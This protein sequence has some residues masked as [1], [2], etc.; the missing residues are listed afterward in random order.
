MRR[1]QLSLPSACR[2]VE[3]APF[4]T[5][6]IPNCF[7]DRTARLQ[8]QITPLAF[9]QYNSHLHVHICLI[10]QITPLSRAPR[11]AAAAN[12]AAPPK[13]PRHPH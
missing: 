10:N 7:L 2:V 1:Q 9:T 6:T 3:A 13:Y 4:T 11:H 5:T 12:H 8:N